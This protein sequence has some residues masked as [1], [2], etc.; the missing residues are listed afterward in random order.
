MR[1]IEISM[2]VDGEAA[3][4]V[5][6]VREML[7]IVERPVLLVGAE[8]H[9]FHMQDDLAQFIER[10]NIPVASTNDGR[11]SLNAEPQIGPRPFDF[12]PVRSL[13]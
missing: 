8:V 11:N 3:E 13:H 2:E 4:A 7:A 6:E 9:R 5:A 1:W 12:D 10:M